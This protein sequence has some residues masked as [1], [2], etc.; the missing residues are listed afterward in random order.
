MAPLHKYATSAH[1]CNAKKINCL[2]L[3]SLLQEQPA[4][5]WSAWS[6]AFENAI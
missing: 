4:K 3:W 5:L 6:R 1:I 2:K